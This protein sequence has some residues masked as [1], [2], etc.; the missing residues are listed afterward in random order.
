MPGSFFM[1]K[2]KNLRKIFTYIVGE[3]G[4]NAYMIWCATVLNN[5]VY[6]LDIICVIGYNIIKIRKQGGNKMAKAGLRAIMKRGHELAR[7]MEGNYQARLALGLRLAWAEYKNKGEDKVKINF[8]GTEKQVKFANDIFKKTIGK[9]L[10]DLEVAIEETEFRKE[11]TKEKAYTRLEETKEK[12]QELNAEDF[13]SKW[14]WYLDEPYIRIINDAQDWLDEVT[15][16]RVSGKA[17][18]TLAEKNYEEI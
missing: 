8:V 7:K 4:L 17:W 13:I 9:V 16:V 2:I 6:G 10:N 15:G 18:M 3:I 1:L 11:S 14:K 12:L 5:L